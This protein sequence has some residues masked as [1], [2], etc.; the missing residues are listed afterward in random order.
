MTKKLNLK[1]WE[2]NYIACNSPKSGGKCTVN[3]MMVYSEIPG[4]IPMFQL[5]KLGGCAGRIYHAIV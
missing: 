1:L 4:P 3:E 2:L 5:H